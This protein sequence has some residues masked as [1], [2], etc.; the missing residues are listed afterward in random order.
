V[1]IT[2]NEASSGGYILY[3][4]IVYAQRISQPPDAALRNYVYM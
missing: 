3:N 1:E 4:I 2:L